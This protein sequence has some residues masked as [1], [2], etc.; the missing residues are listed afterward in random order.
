MDGWIS[1]IYP[2]IHISMFTQ[3]T[4]LMI[5]EIAVHLQGTGC[6]RHQ[7]VIA[8]KELFFMSAEVKVC[9]SFHP[10]Q[11]RNTDTQTYTGTPPCKVK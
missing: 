3:M 2:S 11:K 1:A 5:F 8:S 10:P 6:A 4:I 7:F 9:F